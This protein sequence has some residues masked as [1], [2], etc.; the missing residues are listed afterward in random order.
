[1]PWACCLQD[2][3][4]CG[5]STKEPHCFA[6][7]M[8]PQA[9][10]ELPSLGRALV[11]GDTP[12]W[13]EFFLSSKGVGVGEFMLFHVRV[14]WR[15]QRMTLPR[16]ARPWPGKRVVVPLTQVLEGDGPP[17]APPLVSLLRNPSCA[18]ERV[19]LQKMSTGRWGVLTYQDGLAGAARR[20]S[21]GPP[22]TNPVP[23]ACSRS[24]T[25]IPNSA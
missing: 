6:F 21:L 13:N 14:E 4:R 1:M 15:W 24:P 9:G 16:D 19:T 12:R 23:E 5:V 8:R 18:L 11:P 22:G 20:L 17:H 25:P 3:R 10:A 7:P 2:D